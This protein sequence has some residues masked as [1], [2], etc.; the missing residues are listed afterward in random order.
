MRANLEL[1]KGL[2]FSERVLLKLVQRHA[3]RAWAEGRPLLALL[4]A[5][6]EVTARLP[7]ADL[8]ALF[9]LGHHLRHVDLIFGRV[10]GRV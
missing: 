10:F 7:A 4:E 9:D 6:P 5:D 3:M 1:T 2:I 8:R